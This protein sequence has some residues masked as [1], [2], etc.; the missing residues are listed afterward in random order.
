MQ[1][2][3][4]SEPATIRRQC[5]SPASSAWASARS[6]S[7]LA[8]AARPPRDERQTS[9]TARDREVARIT[10]SLE[11]P[12]RGVGGLQELVR[13]DE[14]VAEARSEDT[15]EECA[16]GDGALRQARRGI[17]GLGQN[18]SCLRVAAG[19][20]EEMFELDLDV[21][22]I[23]RIGDPELERSCEARRG[24]LQRARGG[25]RLRGPP[26]VV[27]SPFGAGDGRRNRE[28]VGELRKDAR[29]IGGMR[30][31][32]RLTDA[33]VELRATDGFDAVVDRTADK[34][35]RET[36]SRYLLGQFV[37]DPAPHRLV[38]RRVQRVS[39]E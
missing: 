32:E 30:S 3:R 36:V 33:Q 20:Q 12:Y 37:E 28:V 18:E 7:S 23:L 9:I 4:A 10:R 24:I 1:T 35:V 5:A 17:E 8:S 39:F 22:A 34:L 13:V 2:T 15:D 21:R 26:V 27:D 38:E 19:L 25:R 31:L 14:W 29:R 11:D 6:S 16:R